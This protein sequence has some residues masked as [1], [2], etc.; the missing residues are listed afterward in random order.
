MARIS[1]S[2]LDVEEISQWPLLFQLTLVIALVLALQAVGYW[3]YLQPKLNELNQLKQ[4]EQQSKT[5]T[6]IA[7]NKTMSL[8]RLEAKIEQLTLR[9][10]HLIGQFPQQKE[11]AKVLAAVNRLALSHT[12]SVT[13]IDWGDKQQ[14]GLLY[15]L[16]LNI[17]LTGSYHDIG[18]FCAAIAALP[19]MINFTQVGWQRVNP[20]SNTIKLTVRAYTYQFKSELTDEL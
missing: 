13:R 3:F 9:Y 5:S 16:P 17:E 6:L 20:D 8:P 12:L 10:D 11:L 18:A 14:Q 2:D 1:F 15:K 4:Q 19:R 7:I